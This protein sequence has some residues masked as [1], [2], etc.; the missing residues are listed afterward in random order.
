MVILGLN[1]AVEPFGMGLIKDGICLKSVLVKSSR[2]NT[3]ALSDSIKA[4][5]DEHELSFSDVSGIGLCVGPG[6]YT[7][8]RVSIAVVKTIA[9]FVNCPVV[10][11]Q[12]LN[13]LYLPYR[14]FSQTICTVI[15]ARKGELN[16]QFF[17]STGDGSQSFS[18]FFSCRYSE[19][20]NF[21]NQFN[22]SVLIVG[23]FPEDYQ[24]CDNTTYIKRVD[25]RIDPIL[26]ANETL[27][28]IKKGAVKTYK[29]IDAIYSHKPV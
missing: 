10:P 19:F 21:L 18:S 12:T 1:Y 29:E 22:K 7:S 24:L 28:M 15:P 9:Q 26:L 17:G 13:A 3:E 25:S 8:L 16:A 5:L 23:I 27:S 14:N 4:L 11:F 6:N 20:N 2:Q